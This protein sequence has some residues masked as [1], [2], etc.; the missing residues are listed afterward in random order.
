MKYKPATKTHDF[1]LTVR[2]KEGKLVTFE[3][4]SKHYGRCYVG[5]SYRSCTK[6]DRG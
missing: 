3:V 6:V 5:S 2:T 1:F 4:P